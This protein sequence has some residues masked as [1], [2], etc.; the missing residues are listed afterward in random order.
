MKFYIGSSFKNIDNVRYLSDKLKEIGLI[1]TYDWTQNQRASTVNQLREIG[2]SEKA[3]V[4][5]SDFVVTLLPAGKGSHIELGMALGQNKKVY[6]HSPNGEIDNFE[7]TSTFYHL[8]E[9]ENCKGNLDDL[10]EMIKSQ[11]LR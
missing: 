8:P 7:T 6:L 9:V 10:I 2:Q 5:E 1:H 4:I 3:A 11:L